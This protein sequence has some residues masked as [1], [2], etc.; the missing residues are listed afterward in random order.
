MRRGRRLAAVVA[1]LLALTLVYSSAATAAVLTFETQFEYD[2]AKLGW[3]T[4]L[5]IREDLNNISALVGKGG[6]T[7][8]PAYP[9]TE[10][11]AS[12]AADV[13]EYLQ[14]YDLK[15]DSLRS[16]YIAI[17][18]MLAAN[19]DAITAGISDSAV[20]GYLENVGVTYTSE[21]DAGMQVLAKALYTA[22]ITG[23]FSGI[24]ELDL[25]GGIS[26]EK[27]LVKYVSSLSGLTQDDVRR[28]APNG[29][30]ALSDYLLAS[31]RYTLWSNGYDVDETT[32]EDRV[33][34]LSAVM[35]IR[36]IGLNVDENASF[37]ELR[38]KYT[39]ALLGKKYNVTVDPDVLAA[40]I[41]SDEA[42]IYLLQLLGQKAGLAVRRDQSLGDAFL[43]VAQNTDAFSI[44]ADEFYADVYDYTFKLSANRSSIWIYPTSYAGTVDGALVN[45]TVNGQP[46]QDNYYTQVKL[47][48][49][50]KE[51]KLEIVV[52]A[53][54]R[55]AKDTETYTVVLTQGDADAAVPGQTPGDLPS[56]ETS[57]TIVSQILRNAGVSDRIVKATDNLIAG[58]PDEVKNAMHFIAPTLGGENAGL[59][60]DASE[61]AV[62][63]LPAQLDTEWV[64]NAGFISIL[65]KLGAVR[66]SSI[67]GIA[68][69]ALAD[70]EATDPYSFITLK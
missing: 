49:D 58:L 51:Q 67:S 34:A 28:F 7:A 20:R 8:A 17:F 69:I 68:G 38:A 46:V 57:G 24:T 52:E 44:E 61:G 31:A 9:Y 66:D 19:A 4:D 36:S 5:V 60:S 47:A 43:L 27:A 30:N 1:A 50:Q 41:V 39:A 70:A 64:R 29:T 54:L 42:P 21:P 53:T 56:Y 33:T 6:L 35:T 18:S 25:S 55:S 48:P 16:S 2:E 37:D 26:L 12:F 10:T 23:A 22:M 40:A 63:G 32:P 11:A 15:E 14:T 59:A 3:L 45:I 62:P 65:D 13:K